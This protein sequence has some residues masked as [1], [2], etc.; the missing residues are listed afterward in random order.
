[1]KLHVVFNFREGAS[2]GANHF[3][4]TLVKYLRKSGHYAQ[5]PADADAVLFNSHH[6][7]NDVMKLKRAFPGKAFVHRIDGPMHLYNRPGD[8]RD[9]LVNLSNR[10]LADGTVF[11][12]EWSK[13]QNLES[14]LKE[15]PLYD[16]ILNAPDPDIFYPAEKQGDRISGA[17]IKLVA[18]SWSSNINKGF[19]IYRFLD[20]NLDFSRY[21]MTFIGNSPFEFK[22][23]RILKTG[24]PGEL[25]GLYRESDI[26]ITASKKDPCSNSLIEALHC[27]LPALALNDGGHPEILGQK[28]LLFE[29]ESDVI[30]KIEKV[31]ATPDKFTG[32]SGLVSIHETLDKY[33]VFC[34]K[35]LSAPP[36]K[37]PGILSIARL[38]TCEMLGKFFQVS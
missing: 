33:L 23:I 29:G 13:K 21:E 38:L 18:S 24:S 25:A 32:G 37:H 11:Q 27:G 35:V 30:E 31:S 2:G 28:A 16:V 1:M 4:A 22:N 14:G 3:L 9:S 20:E 8:R 10:L 7:I 34:E 36:R 15:P 6:F 5:T 26:Y 19:E 12:S 17:K